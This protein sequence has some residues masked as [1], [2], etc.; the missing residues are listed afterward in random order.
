MPN[1]MSSI[2]PDPKTRQSFNEWAKEFNV[3]SCYVDPEIK[4]D[5]KLTKPLLPKELNFWE[6]L[7][8]KIF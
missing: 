3:S 4:N 2:V 6:R 1:I 5:Y 7:Y 8:S